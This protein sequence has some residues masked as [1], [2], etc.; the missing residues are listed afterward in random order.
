MSGQE[1]T[2]PFGADGVSRAGAE[3]KRYLRSDLRR[4]KPV[5]GADVAVCGAKRNPA[6]RAMGDEKAI[7]RVASPV[8]WQSM[9][10]YGHQRD[11][12]NRESRVIHHGVREL[13]VANGEPTDL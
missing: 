5:M 1:R 2:K 12:V 8:E 4:N 6:G 10:N 7:E 3:R 9:T 13:W 11:V